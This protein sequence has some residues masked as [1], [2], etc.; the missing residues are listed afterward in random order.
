MSLLSRYVALLAPRLFTYTGEPYTF[1]FE[2][3]ETHTRLAFESHRV[4]EEYRV[5]IAELQLRYLA[6]M[7]WNTE[8]EGLGGAVTWPL[9]A[10][11]LGVR[12]RQTSD[13][14]YWNRHVIRFV[15]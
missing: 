9:F 15:Q 3:W 12:F 8:R 6:L 4:P 10:S 13:L 11:F 14:T 1:P 7:A 2:E 5:P